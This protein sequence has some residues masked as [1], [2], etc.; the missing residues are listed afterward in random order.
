MSL[1][2]KR[3]HEENLALLAWGRLSQAPASLR[4]TGV[5]LASGYFLSILSL[6]SD[7]LEGRTHTK[8]VSIL[9]LTRNRNLYQIGLKKKTK[10]TNWA[11]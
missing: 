10:R 9:L 3:S 1:G 5:Q 8:S 11:T 2:V 7:Y 6:P 4:A